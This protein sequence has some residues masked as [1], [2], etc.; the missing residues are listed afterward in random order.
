M[1]NEKLIAA[2][3]LAALFAA[4]VMHTPTASAQEGMVVSRDPATGQLRTPTANEMQT[5]TKQQRTLAAPAAKA[6][7]KAV[8]RS[9]GVRQVYMGEASQ[10]Y[11]VVARDAS[12]K[13][14]KRCVQGESAAKAALDQP[15]TV[16]E[17]H[18]HEDR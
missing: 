4:V 18:D 2:L 12:G 7:P 6:Q 1:S 15:A 8:S 14:V 3:P 16:T 10:V 13:L 17:E 5:L 11:T 9:D